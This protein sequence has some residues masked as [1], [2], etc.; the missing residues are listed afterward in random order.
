[1]SD[2]HV[3]YA[4]ESEPES[5]DEGSDVGTD[6]NIEELLDDDDNDDAEFSHMAVSRI[7]DERQ[8]TGFTFKRR[9]VEAET[10]PVVHEEPEPLPETQFGIGDRV[11]VNLGIG[12]HNDYQLGTI[13]SVGSPSARF[14]VSIDGKG[15]K[16]TSSVRTPELDGPQHRGKGVMIKMLDHVILAGEAG[17]GKTHLLVKT[18]AEIEKV[19][20]WL[21]GVGGLA[22]PDP[23]CSS[24]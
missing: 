17:C 13:T 4:G 3:G 14:T 24:G 15:P 11:E 22:C 1:M 7:L 8:S 21:L 18:L 6:G 19:V 9:R 20:A 2:E 12:R 23:S 5:S 10:P 16:T